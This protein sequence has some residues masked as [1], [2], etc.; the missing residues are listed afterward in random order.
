M[1]L[2][3][4]IHPQAIREARAARRWYAQRSVLVAQQFVAELDRAVVQVTS[5]PQSLPSY[6][7]GTRVCRLRRFP[8]L[9]VF[10]ERPAS[11]LVIAIAHARRRPGYWSRRTNRP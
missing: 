5:A 10:I 7:H 9:L 1:P 3:L 11:V 6:L 8:Y 4:E 2:P